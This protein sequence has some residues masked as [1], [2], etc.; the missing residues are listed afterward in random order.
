MDSVPCQIA[1]GAFVISAIG[2]SFADSEKAAT[3]IGVVSPPLR[4]RFL[5]LLYFSIILSML[6]LFG[7]ASTFDHT[8][9]IVNW[10]QGL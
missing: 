10:R 7:R 1:M 4:R 2:N 5:V 6:T 8:E 9:M 3:V